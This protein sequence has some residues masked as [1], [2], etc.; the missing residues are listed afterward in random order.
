MQ[1]EEIDAIYKTVPL[2]RIPW[3]IETPPAVLTGLVKSGKVLPCRAIDL[4]C[5]AGNYAVWLASLGFDVTG[6]DSSPAAIQ[7]ARENAVKKAVRC[8]FIVADLL[9]D[10]QFLEGTFDFAYDYELL[11][12]LLPEERAVYIENVHRLT[13][14]NAMY[15]SVC[16]SDD[17]PQFGGKGKTRK[18]PMGTILYFSSEDEIRDLVSP[19]FRILELKTVEVAAKFGGTHK[20]IYVLC[21]RK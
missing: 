17:D 1:T 20:A 9:G 18:T 21:E 5:G 7:I 10:L 15:L 2:E 11:H 4:G 19:L 6:V 12:H 3:N 8:T 13:R 16:F 14:P